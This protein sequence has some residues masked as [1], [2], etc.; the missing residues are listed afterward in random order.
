VKLP[1]VFLALAAAA[2]P[3]T[4][5]TVT[6][7]PYL[8][9]GG[10]DRV[11]VRW[12]TNVATASR[13]LV[14]PA[15]GQ[16][17]QIF[18]DPATITNH[19]V[20]L[21]GLT[22]G[23]TYHY[24]IGTP[25]QVLAGDDG[26]HFFTTHVAPGTQ[27][28]TRV[29]VL[30]D[31]GTAND[32]ARAVRDAYD[33]FTGAR[34]TDGWLMLGD[35]AYNSGT[36]AEF[37]GA[38]FQAM[39][40]EMLRKSVLWPA[41]GNHDG[42]SADAATQTGP[43]FA[44]FTL[45]KAAEAGGLPSG[46]EA[47]YSFDLANVHF[48]CID[49]S[50]SPS[51]PGSAMATWLQSD[52]Q[53]TDQDW[54]VAYMHHPPY[55][56]GSHDSDIEPLLVAM[57]TNVVPLLEAGGADVVLA[58]HTHA[59]ER[60]FLLQ[61]HYGVSTTLQP[62]MIVDAGDGQLETDGGDG[63]YRKQPGDGTVYVVAGSSGKISGGALNHPIMLESMNLLGSTVLDV[64]GSQ[65][66]VRFID[67]AGAVLDAFT[68]VKGGATP[69]PLSHDV[70]AAQ[71]VWKYHDL[72]IDLGTAW[73]QPGYD[74]AGWAGGAGPLGYGEPG[75]ATTVSFGANPADKHRTTYFRLA[76]SLA[77]PAAAAA[78]S[79]RL[80]ARVDDGLV[81]YLNGVEVARKWMPAG[82]VA[83]ATLATNH[84]GAR[85]E[86]VDLSAHAALLQPGTNVLA[87]E[88][89]QSS[90]ASSDLVFDAGLDFDAFLPLLGPCASGAVG[91][92][93]TVN[94]SAGGL[95]RGVDV[96]ALEP[97]TFAVAQPATHPGAATFALFLD[98]G[99]PNASFQVTVPGIGPICVL[100]TLMLANVLGVGPPGFLAAGPTPW[101]FTFQPVGSPVQFAVQA[102]AE[103]SPGVLRVTNAIAVNVT[104]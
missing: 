79:L 81:A 28:S 33:A 2:A 94:G 38:I 51:G 87:V 24:A 53:A 21:T 52:L 18:Q 6:R 67:D 75:L 23:Q 102:I 104:P 85:Y 49:S 97:V 12:R 57:R 7:G 93:L 19:A 9:A 37:Q 95:A 14:G 58:G 68:I 35:N 91:D 1:I 69:V 70:F 48:V 96:G 66:D 63:A 99:P 74:D 64:N 71:S 82:A 34:H 31:S 40:E 101:S 100:P 11:V 16:L 84:E 45:P 36:D 20:T 39:Y 46:T 47:Y 22:A 60:S 76:F 65:L 26:N 4:A 44:I 27:E 80:N 43:Y 103:E 86:T 90:A 88:V 98:V 59:Y 54:I 41:F 89:H 8:Q 3:A 92:V 5:Q 42:V 73:R 29:W 15:P 78:Q 72:G 83:F 77:D 61:G 55:S 56:Q 32:D 30:G 10:T 17:T 13:V 62:S 50:E 25:T